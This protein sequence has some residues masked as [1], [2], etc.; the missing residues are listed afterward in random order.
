VRL[1]VVSDIRLYR[2][3]LCQIL[4]G[5]AGIEI[6]GVAAS[7]ESAIST[8][9]A[10]RD[11]PDVALLDGAHPNGIAAVGRLADAVPGV[12][13]LVITVRDEASDVIACAEAGAAGFVTRDASIDELIEALE[14]ITLGEVRCSPRMTASLLGHLASVARR[15]RPSRT[16]TVREEQIL[17]LITT[18]LSNK[19][20]AHQLAIELPTVKNHVHR[21]IEKLGVSNRT[22][23]A[24]SARQAQ[25]L[26]PSD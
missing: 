11:L 16:L 24:A 14:G 12:K 18:G 8:I 25:V 9:R 10:L 20:I 26:V 6:A 19:Q 13:V 17:A 21:I 22:Q 23:A 15:P 4:G 7:V 3:G 2:D 5:R 1:F